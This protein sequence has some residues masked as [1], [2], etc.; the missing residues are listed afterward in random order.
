MVGSYPQS[1]KR[2]L[3][4]FI[5]A[6]AKG[7][8]DATASTQRHWHLSMWCLVPSAP[9]ADTEHVCSVSKRGYVWIVFFFIWVV[10]SNDIF[11]FH[12]YL[13]KIPS[14]TNIFQG[15]W[16]HQLVIFCCCSVCACGCGCGG[17]G[18]HPCG[19]R[20]YRSLFVQLEPSFFWFGRF[21]WNKVHLCCTK[22]QC[23]AEPAKYGLSPFPVMVAKEGLGQEFPYIAKM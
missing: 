1:S 18:G 4:E 5:D 12:A 11:Y 22:N 21:L 14:L 8:A 13:G 15:G 10:V 6:T 19:E 2:I 16:N 3:D 9:E 23:P 7:R 20:V 17:G